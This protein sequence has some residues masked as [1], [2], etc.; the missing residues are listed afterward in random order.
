MKYGRRKSCDYRNA[1]KEELLAACIADYPFYCHALATFLQ[2]PAAS[3]PGHPFL[4][5]VPTPLG[6]HHSHYHGCRLLRKELNERMN[7]KVA[8]TVA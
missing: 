6:Y 1:E 4:L 3:F 7:I 8:C 2:L 5:L